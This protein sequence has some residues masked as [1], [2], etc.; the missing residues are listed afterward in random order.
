MIAAVLYL[1]ESARLAFE[2]VNQVPGCFC[3]GHDVIDANTFCPECVGVCFKR[4]PGKAFRPGFFV[5]ADHEINFF[6]FGKACRVDLGRAAGDDDAGVRVVAAGLPDCLPGLANGFVGHRTG[7][8]DDGVA[9][10]CLFRVGFHDFRFIRV[11]PT[12]EGNDIGCCRRSDEIFGTFVVLARPG[13][14]RGPK[15]AGS[16]VPSS[17]NVAGPVIRM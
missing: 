9:E 3:H 5:I 6:H 11:K 1:H 2:P 16:S 12:A 4:Q 13:H 15:N 17:S 10:P 14:D 7:V 8:E